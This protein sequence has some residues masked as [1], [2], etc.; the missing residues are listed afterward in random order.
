MEKQMLFS[1]NFAWNKTPLPPL[2]GNNSHENV[3][4]RIILESRQKC[5][6]G[7]LKQICLL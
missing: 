3:W 5:A 1:L 4:Q 6:N 7:L 2:K